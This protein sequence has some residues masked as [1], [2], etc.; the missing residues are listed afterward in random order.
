VKT[1]DAMKRVSMTRTDRI[2]SLPV[3]PRHLPSRQV[4]LMIGVVTREQRAAAVFMEVGTAVACTKAAGAGFVVCGLTRRPLGAT[5]R[6]L[7]VMWWPRASS[8]PPKG[9][10]SYATRP[11]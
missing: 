5:T 9:G 11:T 1:W 8:P 3:G 4:R 7:L 2:V 6:E 10:G